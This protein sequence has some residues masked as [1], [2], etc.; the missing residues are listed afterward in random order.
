MVKKSFTVSDMHAAF[1]DGSKPFVRF[2]GG[3]LKAYGFKVGDK[4]ELI[5]GRNM[6]ILVKTGGGN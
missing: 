5:P 4:L 2:G 3:W 1:K 6:L